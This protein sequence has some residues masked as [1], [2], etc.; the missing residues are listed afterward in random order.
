MQFLSE[1]SEIPRLLIFLRFLKQVNFGQ[2]WVIFEW[3]YGNLVQWEYSKGNDVLPKGLFEDTPKLMNRKLWIFA[4]IFGYKN[5]TRR[6]STIHKINKKLPFTSYSVT[7]WYPFCDFLIELRVPIDVYPR[8]S[9]YSL[10]FYEFF[11]ERTKIIERPTFEFWHSTYSTD[12]LRIIHEVKLHS[13]VRCIGM[14]EKS[15]RSSL[16]QAACWNCVAEVR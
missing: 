16:L 8:Y 6:E 1:F 5:C 3:I 13:K 2:K 12:L 9:Q 10:Q 11:K 4:K 14:Q 7:R 15:N